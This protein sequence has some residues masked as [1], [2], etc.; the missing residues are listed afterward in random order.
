MGMRRSESS[1]STTVSTNLRRDLVLN[2]WLE[3]CLWNFQ[4]STST[5][6]MPWPRKSVRAHGKCRL[7]RIIREV[8]LEDML[9]HGGVAGEDLVGCV[10]AAENDGGG[11]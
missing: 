4:E 3:T 10:G 6:K 5:L 7:F 9:D 11:G 2:L 8:G 1:V